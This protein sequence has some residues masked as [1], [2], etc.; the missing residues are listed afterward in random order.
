MLVTSSSGNARSTASSPTSATQASSGPSER[1]VCR[2]PLGLTGTP[3]APTSRSLEKQLRFVGQWDGQDVRNAIKDLLT[4]RTPKVCRG[5]TFRGCISQRQ[6]TSDLAAGL[7][8]VM[9]R[10]SSQRIR[11]AAALALP[12][13]SS[14]TIKIDMP[15]AERPAYNNAKDFVRASDVEGKTLNWAEQRLARRGSLRHLGA[16][17]ELLLQQLRSAT[18]AAKARGKVA[19][20]RCVH[21]LGPTAQSRL[22]GRLR[23]GCSSSRAGRRWIGDTSLSES[24]NPHSS[25]T[26]S[27]LRRT[28][29][30]SRAARVRR[31]L[32][33]G[34]VRLHPRAPAQSCC[35]NATRFKE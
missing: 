10:H 3:F 19:N 17:V 32:N 35:R 22:I 31:D 7:R 14:S 29:S 1:S 20:A 2:P 26:T 21:R 16:K 8:K 33:G 25:P 4:R 27:T 12:D 15:A 30:S 5:A 24:S 11:G 18:A 6:A 13:A 34:D 9:I 23:F 28:C